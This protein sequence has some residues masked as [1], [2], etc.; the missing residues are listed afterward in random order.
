MDNTGNLTFAQIGEI[1]ND[2]THRMEGGVSAKNSQAILND[3]GKI[4]SSLEHLIT[5]NPNDFQGVAGIHAQNIVDQLNLEVTAIKSVG[6]D[7][8]AAKYIND[9]QR[10]LI[11]IVQGDTQLAALATQNGHNGFAPVPDLLVKPAQFHGN[12]EQTQ[13][14]Q[15]FVATTQGFADQAM[16]L[17]AN[18]ADPQAIQQLVG[19]IQAYDKT[20]NAFTLAQGGLYSAR[21]NNEFADNGVNGTASRALIDGLQT[22]NADK[23]SAAAQ[24]LVAN[25]QDVVSNMLGLGQ[26]PPAATGNGI[27]DNITTIAQAGTVFNDA[28]TKLI[29]GVYDGNRQSIHDDLTA[30]Q[31]GLNNVIAQGQL[32]QGALKDANRIVGLIGDELKI[33]D[34]PT[35]AANAATQ[36][37]T[38]QNRILAIVHNDTA[39][40]TAATAD[41]ANGF[42]QLPNTLHGNGNG[43]GGGNGNGQDHGGQISTLP[44][45]AHDTPDPTGHLAAI[46]QSDLHHHIG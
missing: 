18:H 37:N 27:P 5:Q 14:M 4:Q 12:A 3:I 23:V 7:P 33:V 39:L 21:F 22:G 35:P 10:D 45:P 36:L 2:A 1:F 30:T 40:A 32:D 11:D 46:F 42:M 9:V 43:N 29:G 31:Q 8:F 19:Q 6:T 17:V 28:T 15:N 41:G 44:T 25:S 16:Q 20:A 34:N 26:T 38:L 13:F 24:V